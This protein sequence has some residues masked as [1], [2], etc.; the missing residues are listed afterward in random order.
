LPLGLA[1]GVFGRGGGGCRGSSTGLG[2]GAWPLAVIR[3]ASSVDPVRVVRFPSNGHRGPGVSSRR[4]LDP[5]HGT[6]TSPAGKR[7]LKH[8]SPSVRGP[9]SGI[10]IPSGIERAVVSRP[11]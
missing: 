1:C 9:S 7:W 4:G 8:Q 6:G 10:S 3:C 2:C 5:A 11:P